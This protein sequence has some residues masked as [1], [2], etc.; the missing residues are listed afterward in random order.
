MH[1]LG[2]YFGQRP[3]LIGVTD[4]TALTLSRA[5]ST[6]DG[7]GLTG[8]E[9]VRRNLIRGRKPSRRDRSFSRPLIAVLVALSLAAAGSAMT[10]ATTDKKDTLEASM[11]QSAVGTQGAGAST[12][13]V[14]GAREAYEQL[15]LSFV[16]NEGQLDPRVRYYAQGAGFAFYFTSTS[17]RL[18]LNEK[19]EGVALDLDFVG[20][21]AVEPQARG[22]LPGTVNYMIGDDPAAWHTGLATSEQ[23]VYEDL[24]PGVDMVFFGEDGK[25]K[26][27]FHVAPGASVDDIRL[28]YRGS[29]GVSLSRA[30]DML[31]STPLGTL[32][33]EAP[34]SF[35]MVGG[36]RVPV[37]S[38]FTLDARGSSGF[39]LGAYDPRRTLIIDPGLDYSTY[40]GG[41]F[42]DSGVGIA[43][44]GAGSAYVTGET[45]SANFPTTAGA[46]QVANAGVTG[47]TDV[48][49]TKLNPTG[50]A[51]AYSTYLGGSFFDSGVGIAVD[52][53]GSAYVTGLTGSANF[54]TT[55]GAF[56]GAFAGSTDV[57]VTKLNPTG[58]ALA[59]STYLGGSSS[60]FDGG[61][62]VD[63][64]GSAY[65]TGQTSS[66]NFP[67][68]A[69]AFQGANAGTTD[70]FVTKIT[71]VGEPATVTL[72]PPAAENTVGTTHT[73]TATVTDASGNPVPDVT[74]R[75]EVTGAV[76]ASGSCTTDAFGQCTFT[77]QGPDL[78]GEDTITAFADGDDDGT[79]DPGEPSGQATK[80][81]VLPAST[82]GCK[83]SNGGR[84][85]ATNGDKAT[86]G[87]NAKVSKKD[88]VKGQQQYQDHGPGQRMK[89]HSI[90]IDA[91]VCNEE[92]TQADIFGTA[93]IDK[94]GPH[95][96]RITVEDNGEPGRGADRYQIQ[97]DNGYDSG[98]QVLEGGNIQIKL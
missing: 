56:Q 87:G 54:P 67:T 93:T 15:P 21:R 96:F 69:G 74:V 85:T 36:R 11:S 53:A 37:E 32:T 22:Q 55:A 29:D 39:T 88:A 83:V 35:Q 10:A 17:A 27:D 14:D 2:R 80:T 71:T 77:Y 43:V 73:V 57:F 86:F 75:F 52:G 3:A 72:D 65:V 25:L 23:V 91:L 34:V 49:V 70:A 24:W 90:D 81:W 98:L 82:A 79:Q 48:I 38:A 5:L 68:T 1:A 42:F 66:A 76:N 31:I 89:V 6:I 64:A 78:P 18:V 60:D 46:F 63:G 94:A 97:L 92:G 58:T 40:L 7:I 44:D 45:S 12:A 26:Y 50:T 61:I 16:S 30:G 41:S 28:A 9:A 51:L 62:A 47:S 84:I 33:D 4:M 59:Y 13:T 20:A 95:G 19:D 8:S